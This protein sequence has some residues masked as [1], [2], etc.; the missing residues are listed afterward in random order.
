MKRVNAGRFLFYMN[1]RSLRNPRREARCEVLG[2]RGCRREVLSRSKKRNVDALDVTVQGSIIFQTL[3]YC[4]EVYLILK[5][6]SSSPRAKNWCFTLNNYTDESIENIQKLLDDGH[7]SYVIYGRE[8]GESGTPHLQGFITFNGRKRATQV[9]PL[10]PGAHVTV[11]RNVNASIEYCRKDGDV[12]E[13]GQREVGQGGRSDLEAFKEDVKQ[14]NLDLKSIRELHSEV[15][16][17]HTRFC[18]EYIQDH[19]PARSTPDHTLRPWQAELKSIVDGEANDRTIVFVVDYVGNS[20]KSWFAH[21][22]AGKNDRCQVIQPAKKADM[23][24]AL[25]PTIRVL[26]VDAPRSKQ[27]EYLQYDFLE[28][29]KNGY[30]FSTKYESRVKQLEKC[31]VIVMMNEDPDMEK[32]SQDRYRIISTND[33]NFTLG[34]GN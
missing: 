9:H 1:E 22:Y 34:D 10:L 26:F 21:W 2:K 8:V 16:A 12:T 30:V 25:D 27:G 6:M 7:A 32:L 13:L 5:A 14:G 20:G 3:L 23:A 24:Y 17:K 28:D 19:A 29:V 11:A 18:L 33:R 15:Y 4:L 31:H